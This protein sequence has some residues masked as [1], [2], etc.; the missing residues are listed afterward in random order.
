[1]NM[2]GQQTNCPPNVWRDEAML[3]GDLGGETPSSQNLKP[4]CQNRKT[5]TP[6]LQTNRTAKGLAVNKNLKTMSHE[7]P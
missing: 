5:P 7:K 3:M 4:H 2:L 1:M 6:K